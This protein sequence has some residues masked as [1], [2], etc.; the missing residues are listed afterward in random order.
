MHLASKSGVDDSSNSRGWGLSRL[1]GHWQAPQPGM[2]VHSWRRVHPPIPGICFSSLF[3]VGQCIL[4]Q[5]HIVCKSVEYFPW[6][7]R[8]GIKK[9]KV[10]KS[11]DVIC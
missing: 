1:M 9:T 7:F 2:I 11:S 8:R 3:S 6:N 5:I 10:C 4:K